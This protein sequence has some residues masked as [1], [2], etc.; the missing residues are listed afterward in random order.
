VKFTQ[1]VVSIMISGFVSRRV[2]CTGM[3]LVLLAPFPVQGGTGIEK[4]LSGASLTKQYADPKDGVWTL[5]VEFPKNEILP[6][7]TAFTVRVRAFNEQR[8]FWEGL[9]SEKRRLMLPGGGRLGT[10]AIPGYDQNFLF[11]NVIIATCGNVVV[12]VVQNKGMPNKEHEAIRM[13]L[14]RMGKYVRSIRT[15]DGFEFPR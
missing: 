4:V 14:V 10:E 1:D 9:I 7:K 2:I 3:F 6:Y 8:S 12:I 5:E 13:L 11:G 15:K